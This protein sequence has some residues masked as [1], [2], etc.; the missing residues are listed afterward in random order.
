MRKTLLN[1]Y[2]VWGLGILLLGDASYSQDTNKNSS[3]RARIAN[4]NMQVFGV[5]K[6]KDDGLMRD[7]AEI[8]RGYDIFFIQEIRDK[9][10]RAF[11]KLSDMLT[12]YN[13]RV[14]S[15]AGKTSSKEQIGLLWRKDKN[16][17]LRKLEDYN[18]FGNW[19][20][21]FERAPVRADFVFSNHYENSGSYTLSVF[22]CHTDPDHTRKEMNNLE[23]IVDSYQSFSSNSG[24]TVLIGDLNADGNFYNPK[25]EKYFKKTGNNE[26][27]WH[28][29]I[30][31]NAD[32]TSKTSTSNA[33]DRI[34]VNSNAF[35]E[36][37]SFG[38]YTNGI[39]AKHSDHYVVYFEIMTRER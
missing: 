13:S 24:N 25:K 29:L 19:S 22:S 21:E 20:N 7:Y 31:D 10:G 15:R 2:L 16:I 28:W 38:V 32:T 39:T 30:G 37:L 26:S 1:L 5:K 6:A 35:R 4:W 17:F 18:T 3:E 23:T 14:S 27:N 9:S 11:E 33:Y 34:I 8:I 12:N 36:V